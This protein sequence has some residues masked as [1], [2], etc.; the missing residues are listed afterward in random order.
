MGRE[1]RRRNG[2]KQPP[3]GR[4]VKE[5]RQRGRRIG[6]EKG[7]GTRK[8]EEEEEEEEE[9]QRRDRQTH[10]HKKNECKRREKKMMLQ[11]N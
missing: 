9:G 6:G 8:E 10:T 5:G 11:L 1:R 2:I 3:K 7:C 4:V